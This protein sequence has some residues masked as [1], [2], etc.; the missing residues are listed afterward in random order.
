[1]F[2]DVVD[3]ECP[4]GVPVVCVSN[5]SISFLPSSVPYLCSYLLVFNLDVSRR[6]LHPYG[7]LWVLLELVLG[8]SQEKVGLANS[9]VTDE[10][11]LKEVVVMLLLAVRVVLLLIV[12]RSSTLSS[13]IHVFIIWNYYRFVKSHYCTY[14]VPI[15]RRVLLFV[16]EVLKKAIQILIIQ[17]IVLESKPELTLELQVLDVCPWDNEQVQVLDEAHPCLHLNQVVA[18]ATETKIGPLRVKFKICCRA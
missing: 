11:Y 6:K 12:A 5:R 7:W 18:I 10:D 13:S 14:G 8:V 4:H 15:Q 17:S 3:Q 2:R 1:M 9:W 16:L